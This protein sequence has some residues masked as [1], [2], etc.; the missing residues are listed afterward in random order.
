MTKKTDWANAA[1]L[2]LEELD[3]LLE[4]DH[5]E[6]DD[7]PP[8]TDEELAAMRPGT[9]R[10]GERGPGRRAAKVM[11]ALRVEQAT[12]E[13][14]RASGSGWQTRMGELL[15]REAPHVKRRA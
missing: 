2:P 3:R 6:V 14:W 8:L 13:A 11:V 5:D 15:S 12:L 7:N 10:P 9:R 1:S 4:E